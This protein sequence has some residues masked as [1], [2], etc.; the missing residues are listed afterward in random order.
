MIKKIINGTFEKCGIR[1]D[2]SNIRYHRSNSRSACQTED[3]FD[4]RM[5]SKAQQVT[6][7]LLFTKLDVMVETK[8]ENSFL[9]TKNSEMVLC[10]IKLNTCVFIVQNIYC[11]IPENTS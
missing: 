4:T 8:M 5:K 3:E 10:Y 1:G 9:I 11:H 7:I 2:I 6:L